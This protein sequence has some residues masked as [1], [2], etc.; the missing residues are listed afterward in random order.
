MVQAANLR[1]R[2]NPTDFRSLDGPRLRR[3][4]VQSQ[5][6]PALVII[7][8]EATEVAAQVALSGNDH[9]IQAL[10]RIVPITRSM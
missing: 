7:G 8:H 10:R 5:V 3:I 6:R 9:V 4:L 2:D 1:K